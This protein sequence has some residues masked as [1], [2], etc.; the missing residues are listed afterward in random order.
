MAINDEKV[1]PPPEEPGLFQ[2]FRDRVRRTY[3]WYRDRNFDAQAVD[4]R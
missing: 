3:E 1:A 4:V 2:R